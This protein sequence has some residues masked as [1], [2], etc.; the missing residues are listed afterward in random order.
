MSRTI[1]H[2]ERRSPTAPTSEQLTRH[3]LALWKLHANTGLQ[4][5]TG[6]R[7]GQQLAD[8]RKPHTNNGL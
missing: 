1:K 8:K 6:P 4:Y 3:H 2:V 7:Y 5:R